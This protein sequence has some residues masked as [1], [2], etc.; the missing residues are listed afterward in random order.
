MRSLLV[1]IFALW[2]LLLMA[3]PVVAQEPYPP[4]TEPGDDVVVVESGGETTGVLSSGSE[5]LAST[6]V[7]LDAG[8]ITAGGLLL[9][10]TGLV[11]V[12]RRRRARGRA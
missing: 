11:L 8:T 3:G 5:R 10:G 12:A 1:A 7:A 6:G 9:A 4:P 2:A